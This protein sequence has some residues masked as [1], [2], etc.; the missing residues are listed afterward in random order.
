MAI[1]DQGQACDAKLYINSMKEKGQLDDLVFISISTALLPK[2][3]IDSFA[4]KMADESMMPEIRVKDVLVIDTLGSPKPGN[5]VVVKI[6]N[7]SEAI[8]CQ[9]KKVSYTSSD[10]ELLTLNDNWPNISVCE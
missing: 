8:I 3:S 2:L 10:F 4:L 6:E 9:Y 5:Y 7:K 1:L